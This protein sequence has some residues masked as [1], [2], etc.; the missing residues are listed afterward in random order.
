MDIKLCK[1]SDGLSKTVMWMLRLLPHW[2]DDLYG[3]YVN[4][5][6]HLEFGTI[7]KPVLEGLESVKEQIRG[8]IAVH[9]ISCESIHN[10]DSP[11]NSLKDQ[12]T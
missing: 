8:N 5:K 4:L 11:F 2:S 3:T 6:C 10:A 9:E 7:R 12:R 1:Y